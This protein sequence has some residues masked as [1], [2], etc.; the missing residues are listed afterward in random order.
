MDAADWGCMCSCVELSDHKQIGLGYRQDAWPKGCHCQCYSKL[1]Q[2][3][4]KNATETTEMFSTHRP[5]DMDV[6]VSGDQM[7]VLR[8]ARGRFQLVTC[9]H[10]H[11]HRQT[12]YN[13]N[14]YK[15]YLI[16]Y[17]S[18]GAYNTVNV[19]YDSPETV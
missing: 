3:K 19:S 9:Q 11:L 6:L 15:L 14:A 7:S 5:K 10:P 13:N 2:K 8:C 1:V 18:P 16:G 17:N 12:S 4:P